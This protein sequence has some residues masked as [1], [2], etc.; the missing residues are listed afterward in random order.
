MR[1]VLL[2]A[3]LTAAASAQAQTVEEVCG[4]LIGSQVTECM[5]A[6]NGKF[7]SPPA[8][9]ECGKLI[10]SQV[11]SCMRAAAGKDISPG[12]A[13]TCGELIGSQVIECFQRTGTPHVERR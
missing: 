1:N 11:I 8:A 9:R 2:F 3:V 10:G 13:S 5:G 6:V 12:Q 7:F 4:T